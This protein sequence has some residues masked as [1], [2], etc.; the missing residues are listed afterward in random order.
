MDERSLVCA[1][2]SLDGVEMLTYSQNGY[3][4]IR[5]LRRRYP[6]LRCGEYLISEEKARRVA[7]AGIL[8]NPRGC[9]S[10]FKHLCGVAL[11]V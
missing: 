9:I 10:F 5:Q 3:A 8:L 7:L 4:R 11:R 1:L 6:W 2:S